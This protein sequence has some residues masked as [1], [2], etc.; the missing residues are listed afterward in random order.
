LKK[1]G[2]RSKHWGNGKKRSKPGVHKQKA[3]QLGR[4]VFAN[5][6][7]SR[8]RKRRVNAATVGNGNGLIK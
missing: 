8:E 4:G 2:N 6:R 7:R 1:K 3:R 5:R